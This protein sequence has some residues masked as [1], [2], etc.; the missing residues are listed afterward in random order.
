M[1]YDEELQEWEDKRKIIKPDEKLAHTQELFRILLSEGGSDYY[2]SFCNDNIAEDDSDWHCIRCKTCH[3]W[4]VYR[5]RNCHRCMY[6]ILYLWDFRSHSRYTWNDFTM[7]MVWGLLEYMSTC[8][9]SFFVSLMFIYTLV[10][11]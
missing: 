2:Y 11:D 9:I 3:D 7:P 10:I 6:W 5:C 8:W 1:D 4:R